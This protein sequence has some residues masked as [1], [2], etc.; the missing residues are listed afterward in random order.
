[1]LLDQF[2][3][4]ERTRERR[5]ERGR[6]G[7]CGAGG[8]ENAL[9]GPAQPEILTRRGENAGAELAVARLHTPPTRPAA[10]EIHRRKQQAQAVDHRHP[11]AVQRIGLDRVD[12]IGGAKAADDQRG[13]AEDEPTDRGHGRDAQRIDANSS[14]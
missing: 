13:N 10:F 6:D 4:V 3:A 5:V 2:A 11:P 14:R 12:D 1:M 8:D 7:G 9:I